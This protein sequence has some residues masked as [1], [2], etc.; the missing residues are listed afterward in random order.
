M[1]VI[2]GLIEVVC[3]G[4]D[5]ETE[6]PDIKAWMD[7]GPA[8]WL[9]RRMREDGWAVALPGGVDRCPGCRATAGSR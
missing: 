9:R 3:D 7:A 2:Q 4:P 5:G 6:C 8:S 1:S